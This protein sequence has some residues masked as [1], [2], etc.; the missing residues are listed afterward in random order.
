MSQV[1]QNQSNLSKL[2]QEINQY[3]KEI[4]QKLGLFYPEKLPES[5][6]WYWQEL[7]YLIKYSYEKG[8]LNETSIKEFIPM[9]KD[10]T[11]REKNKYLD[12]F[13][14]MIQEK[15][16]YQEYLKEDYYQSKIEDGVEEGK[17]EI[18]EELHPLFDYL[19][20]SYLSGIEI[21]QDELK[22]IEIL[23]SP[24]GQQALAEIKLAKILEN[25]TKNPLNMGKVSNP[26]YNKSLSLEDLSKKLEDRIKT[27]EEN[28][29]NQGNTSYNSNFINNNNQ[30]NQPYNTNNNQPSTNT[31]SQSQ[32]NQPISQ[33]T[34]P[35]IKNRLGKENKGLDELLK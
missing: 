5:E 21:S 28:N 33:I 3:E 4:E 8:Y 2:I 30:N 18:P 34:I 22:S 6:K 14:K 12:N 25:T 11:Y 10:F 7:F 24:E 32:N 1:N 16:M 29:V 26:N 31:I 17:K 35:L 9:F 27:M 19:V 23:L 20:Y 15:D 13:N